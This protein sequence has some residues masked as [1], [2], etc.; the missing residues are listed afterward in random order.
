MR[1]IKFRGRRVDKDEFVYGYLLTG[2]GY[3]KR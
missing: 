1:E 2:M 3:K